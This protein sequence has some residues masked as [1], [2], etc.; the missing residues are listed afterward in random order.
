MPTSLVPLLPRSLS[1]PLADIADLSHPAASIAGR[2]KMRLWGSAA[3]VAAT[4]LALPA[5]AQNEMAQKFGARESVQQISLSPDGRHV[6]FISPG[7]GPGTL[8]FVAPTD[9]SGVKLLV[10]LDGKPEQL[11]RCAWISIVRLA[12]TVTVDHRRH[13]MV[14]GYS[15]MFALNIDRTGVKQLSAR[16]S[17]AA[18]RVAQHGGSVIDWLPGEDGAILMTREFVPEMGSGR[19]NGGYGVERID[20]VTLDRKIIERPHPEVRE[21]I[22]DGRG[23][24]R[25]RGRFRKTGEGYDSGKIEYEYRAVGER[26]WEPLSLF[27][28]ET[29]SGFN[30]YAVDPASNSAYGF[31]TH[32]GR[33]ALFRIALDGSDKRELVFSHDD[34]DVDGLIRIGRERRVVGVS[35][36]T[37]R[38]H[39]EFF[40]PELKRFAAGLKKALPGRLINFVDASADEKKLL[41]WAG[42]DVDPGQY[43]VLDK[44]TRELSGVL[45]SR[46]ELGETTLAEVKP[47]EYPAADGTMIPGYLTLPPGSSGKGLPAIVLPHGGPGARDEW[48][49]DWLAQYFVARGFA[50]LQPNFRGSAGYGDAWFQQNGFQSWKVAVGDVNDGG[51][52]LVS[53]G[54]ARPDQ[55][56]IVGWSYGGYAALQSAVLDPELFKAIVAIAPVTD[57]ERLKSESRGFTSYRIVDRFVGDGPHVR[58]G[59]PY[60]NV[61]RIS[62]PVLMFHGDMDANVGVAHSREMDERL[63]SARKSSEFVLF[64]GLDHYLEDESARV[65]MLDKSD[66]FLR[67][68]MGM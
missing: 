61:E 63:R 65:E 45:L 29:G 36:A 8:L 48:G 35:Y 6:A 34:V 51:K 27:D 38:R 16:E 4:A 19:V 58:E 50:V 15:R 54:I 43:Y 46:P 23:T 60:R 13:G 33:Q 31:D 47:I 41:I 59:S 66:A 44:A 40:D 39:A 67:R 5:A 32:Q 30:P 12:C 28:R 24:I 42:S 7:D 53:Q 62:A 57:L 49:F 10:T 20:S 52:W 68:S 3:F 17:S 18:L 25:L 14:I 56:G 11:A 37:D 9:G 64:K 22:T 26:K 2:G 21:Y 1:N 55:L